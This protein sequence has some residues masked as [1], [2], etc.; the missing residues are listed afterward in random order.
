MKGKFGIDMSAN[1]DNTGDGIMDNLLY[2]DSVGNSEPSVG[3][4]VSSTS[5]TTANT[6]ITTTASFSDQDTSDT[7]TAVWN[8]G[9]GNTTA[10]TVTE[11]NGS[12]SVLDS[13]TYTTAG[14]YT[15]TLTVID[16]NN[17]S[18][19]STYQYVVVYD[20]S[21]G[22]LTGSGKYNSQAG[23][24]VQNPSATGDFKFGVQAKYTSANTTPTGDT[25]FKFQAGNL[26]F[27]ATSY[28]W[29]V[30]SGAKATLKGSGTVNG[31]GNYT[32]LISAID[33][34]QTNG[35]NLIR[36][37]IKDSSNNIIYDTQAGDAD[38]ADPTT[39]LANGTIKVH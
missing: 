12:G 29:L 17:A 31:S 37:Q 10:G 38:T 2:T 34:S 19:S 9:D 8:W 1:L 5:L 35:Q 23:W 18:G 24:D 32:F 13:H 27:D 6:S 39:P 30:V 20:P 22:F 33:G 14:V 11:S 28:L 7:H 36:V 26:D 21:A 3:P 15:V 16:N 25:K 4:V